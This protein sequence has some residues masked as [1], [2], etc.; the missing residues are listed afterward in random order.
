[1]KFGKQI[2][3]QQ[4]T[5]WSSFY[6]DYKGLKKFISSLLK[7]PE[8]SL[9]ALG[10]PAIGLD[11]DRAKLLQ[12]QKA[13][14]FFK[15]EREL[16]KI[17][18][19]YLQK[20]NE[21]KVRL[22]TLIDKKKVL[23]SDLRR[24]KHASTLFKSIQEAFVQFEHEL[25][26]IQKYVELNNEGFRKI[27][28]KWDKRSKSCTKELYLS[29]QIDIQP[30]F[31][32]QVLCELADLA[33]ANRIELSNIL[34]GI[35]VS[36]PPNNK[37]ADNMET[38]FV[39]TGDEIDDIE[40]ELVK[41]VSGSQTT[42]VK[43]ILGR[44]TANPSAEDHGRLTRVFWNACSEA[45]SEI[46]QLLI[47]TG[48]VNF[49]YVDDIIERTCLHVAAMNGRLDIL[50]I[51]TKHGASVESTDAYGRTALHYATMNGFSDCVSFLLK[52]NSDIECR[53]H[54]GFSPLIYSIMNGHTQCVEILI[55]ANAN[56]E[57]RHEG[58][59]IPLSLACHFG[60][61]DIAL[62]LYHHGAKNLPNAESLYPLHLAARQGHAELCRVLAQ[63]KQELEKPDKYNTWTPLFWAANDGHVDCVRELI[64]AGCKINVKDENNKTALYYAAWEGHMDCVQLLLDAGCEVESVDQ[65]IPPT[66]SQ[67]ASHTP[68]E[69]DGNTADDHDPVMDLDGLDMIPSLS[70]P[71]PIIPFR[72]YG[73]SYL[74]RKYQIQIS[75]KQPPIR[76]YDNAQISSLRLIISSKPD[77]G[78]IPHSV[79]LPLVD[80]RDVFN[81]QVD[82]LDNFL[83]EFDIL[84]TFGSK[85]LGRAVAL[86]QLFSVDF[87]VGEKHCT[88]P[89]LDGHL[90]VIGE[91]SYDYSVISPF[92]GVQLEIGG[93]IETYWKSTNT[94]LP[95]PSASSANAS[96]TAE[97]PE[98][99]QL[100]P[101][102]TSTTITQNIIKENSPTIVNNNPS[103]LSSTASSFITASS[104]SGD[105]VQVVVQLTRDLIPVVYANWMIPYRGLDLTVSDVTLEQF[106][107]IGKYLLKEEALNPDEIA[108]GVCPVTGNSL[109]I[110]KLGD[111]KAFVSL[112]QVLEMLPPSMGLH[113]ELKYPLSSDLTL[114]SFTNITDR[115]TFVDT[116][117]QCIYDHVRSLPANTT[118]RSLFFSSYNP[119]ICMV[120]SWKQPN[121]AV[122]FGT[123]CGAN[124][125]RGT[126][127]RKTFK[128]DSIRTTSTKLQQQG[129]DV[130]TEEEKA[131][132]HDHIYKNDDIRCSSLKEAVKFAKQNNLLGM[133]CGA[134]TL[135]QVPSL[136]KTAK[137]SGLILVT[138]GDVNSDIRYR[139]LQ[140]RY[141]VD[142]M[143]VNQ[144]VHFNTSMAG[145]GF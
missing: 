67:S 115:N 108:N 23:Q 1:M 130:E 32:T 96:A 107:N 72:I 121:Y 10:L 126:K 85:V 5:E 93:R 116:V 82:R 41:A 111:C 42:V 54:D 34:E 83:L 77:T 106:L 122:F 86:P 114:H 9:K 101:R 137:E 135:V 79:I 88:I 74:D 118:S 60:H 98:Q 37:D 47:N 62:M 78:M 103:S 8:D 132:S 39:A 65:L 140:E 84:A 145:A 55:R 69:S 14:F 63:N 19:F 142:A 35:P 110:Q 18:S 123:Y 26:K 49:K 113:L 22:R 127:R 25:T 57:P 109:I 131:I 58:D 117:L 76:L 7:T 125:H 89:L 15:L 30:C 124:M 87:K 91:L 100:P 28:K 141:G 90:K 138:A 52:H 12:S 119:A 133:I 112:E 92:Q 50:E 4:F 33:S 70:L 16:E 61:T 94:V 3:S 136:I 95:Q 31:N 36:P 2:Q 73:H 48:L 38:N 29:R 144:V 139:Q 68:T 75:L 99:Q 97:G 21:L 44:I 53:D 66:V 24:L 120:V 43:D 13:A 80:D 46:T 71:P 104:L 105:Y 59:H 51:C 134:H 128:D 143:V 102:L 40:L 17:N 45:S 20:E 64:D 27:L 6:L 81:F 56:I 129:E 11:G